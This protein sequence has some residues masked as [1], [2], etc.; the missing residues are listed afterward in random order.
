MASLTEE[1]YLKLI[2]H[3]SGALREEVSTSA[4][5]EQTQTKAASVTDM[6]KK[7][8]EKNLIH[9]KRYQGVRLTEEGEYMALKVIRRHRLWEVFMVEK[10]GFR[11]DEV[12]PIAE[13]LEHIASDELIN[14]LDA[15]LNFPV[16]DP[17]G[18]PIP[19]ASGSMPEADYHKLCDTSLNDQVTV[20]GV[21]E[22]ASS[23][24]QFL[25]KAGLVPGST[26]QVVEINAFDRS[27][28]IRI[29]GLEPSFI[30]HE[31][32]RNIL[33]SPES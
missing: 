9:Y 2:Y 13:E 12:H 31:V 4:L 30:S 33:V 25:S 15:F 14:R 17:H 3:L 32:A 7:L 10:L 28:Q 27:M 20:M 6:L 19:T 21:S 26:V 24:L 11:W 23:F 1:N 22:H 8:A 18:D 29:N 5:A 16:S